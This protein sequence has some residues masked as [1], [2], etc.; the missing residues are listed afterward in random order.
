MRSELRHYCRHCRSKLKS[1][2]AN[3]REAFCVS[4]CHKSFYRHRCIVCERDMPRNAEN[5]RTCYRAECKTA[6]RQKTISSRF[7]GDSSAPVKDPLENPIKSGLREADKYGRRWKSVAGTLSPNAF[8]CATVPDAPGRK[9][10]GGSFERIEAQNRAAL[11]S[12]SAMLRA[13]EEAEI[14]ANGYFNEPDW[15]EV[16]SPDGVRC[17]VTSANDSV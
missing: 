15:R 14:E 10:E 5:Q 12:L 17:F 9:W 11:K 1:P 4:G 13:A 16:V 2:V 7:V 8:H 6:W 3:H